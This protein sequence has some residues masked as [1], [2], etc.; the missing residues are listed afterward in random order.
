MSPARV[1][2]SMLL[3]VILPCLGC[4]GSSVAR[5]PVSGTVTLDGAP[6]R[7]GS[8]VFTGTHGPRAGGIIRAGEFSITRAEGPVIGEL[9]V[10]IRA[11]KLADDKPLPSDPGEMTRLAIHAPELLPERYNTTSILSVVAR[12][13]GENVFAFELTS[14]EK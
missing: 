4:G 8:I 5:V 7:Y 10:E 11:P 3:A 1:V 12:G 14:A 2:A 13:D 6:L 9:R